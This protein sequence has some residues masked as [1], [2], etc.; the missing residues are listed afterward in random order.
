MSA[1]P[2]TSNTTNTPIPPVI[3]ENKDNLDARNTSVNTPEAPV[4]PGLANNEPTL[5]V[6]PKASESPNTN[7]TT[8]APP[9]PIPAPTISAPENT[10]GVMA[11][12][13]EAKVFIAEV[14]E[15]AKAFVAQLGSEDKGISKFLALINANDFEGA[16]A[17]ALKLDIKNIGDVQRLIA[18]E[19]GLN[20]VTDKI[21]YITHAPPGT[22]ERLIG[23]RSDAM[24]AFS[25]GD[26]DTVAMLLAKIQ[27][28]LKDTQLKFNQEG[29]KIA[30]QKR[31][32]HQDERSVKL[33]ET[34]EKLK[35]S[36]TTDIISR[37]FGGIATALSM[38]IGFILIGTG[39]LA[40]AGIALTLV[41]MAVM[42]AV[43]VSQ[44]T[45]N[46]MNKVF[47][48]SDE[49]QMAAGIFWS[50]LGIVL[51]MGGGL[52]TSKKAVY[53]VVQTTA[54]TIKQAVQAAGPFL[55]TG[56]RIAQGV[57]AIGQGAVSMAE[58]GIQIE[59]GKLKSE[60]T[61]LNAHMMQMQMV[62]DNTMEVLQKVIRELDEGVSIAS[63]LIQSSS[64]GKQ[65]LAQ[66]I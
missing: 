44:N 41:G 9:L 22:M 23:L 37:V 53:E 6:A 1:L 47:G 13:E 21:A 54:M 45:G 11:Q 46:W 18:L 14:G 17:L 31:K 25:I 30:E 24:Q 32:V 33:V 5:Q 50:V 62:M 4:K 65:K 7:E 52:I 38:I 27:T 2:N 56:A 64:S 66:N 57:T 35:S 60:T 63:D 36:E 20:E 61:R 15:L 55:R 3:L 10:D 16:A 49:G 39:V 43:T 59:V 42:A 29:L 34:V 19:D 28:E 48:E 58:G 26:M 51:S 8:S 12:V 40:K